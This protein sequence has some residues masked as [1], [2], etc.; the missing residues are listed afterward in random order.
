MTY[1]ALRT[2]RTGPTLSAV[3]RLV[4][5]LAIA[6]TVLAACGDG[7]PAEPAG[8]VRDPAPVVASVELPDASPG[9]QPCATKAAPGELLLVYFGFT[10][11]PDV[12]PTTLA[13]VRRAV[14]NLDEDQ[15]ALVALAVITVD[16]GRDNAETLTAY[17]QTWVSGAHALRTDDPAALRT[18]ADAYG[19]DYLVETNDE[20]EIEVGHTAFLYA[21][22]SAGRI[23]LTWPFGTPHEDLTSDM[24]YLFNEGV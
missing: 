24:E 4:I 21:V 22:D 13:D 16:P 18:A 19:A 3:T 14:G 1:D 2:M 8:I 17:A 23:R 6:V 9:G 7:I 20:G 10:S 12:C 15:A 11:C 5:A